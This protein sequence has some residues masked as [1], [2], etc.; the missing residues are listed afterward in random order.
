MS[1]EAGDTSQP[2]TVDRTTREMEPF[3]QA[4]QITDVQRQM[5]RLRWLGQMTWMSRKADRAQRSYHW[6]RMITVVGG[7]TVPALVS[8]SLG[9]NDP[10]WRWATFG[11]SLVV[12]I[13]AA[14]E[15]LYQYGE[16]WRH[17][18]RNAELLK[19]EGWQYL[20][21]R[22]AELLKGEGWQYLLGVGPYRRFTDPQDAF[23]TFMSRVEAI[24]QEDVQ[25]FLE[26]VTRTTPTERHDVFTKL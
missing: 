25:G 6:L 13:T 21:R 7:V 18:R 24:L 16:R 22:N 2:A 20:H 14:I 5:L 17:Y 12:A 15:S 10:V 3:L 19:G 4:L 23:R 11:V 1:V 8:I 9:A 26:E